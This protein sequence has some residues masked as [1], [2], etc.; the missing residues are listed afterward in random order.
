MKK[1]LQEQRQYDNLSFTTQD[2]LIFKNTQN[3]IFYDFSNWNNLLRKEKQKIISNYIDNLVVERKNNK[4][5][6]IEINYRS[7]F[8]EILIN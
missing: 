2:L 4:T 8:I 3:T 7:S 5:N 6:I 1:K